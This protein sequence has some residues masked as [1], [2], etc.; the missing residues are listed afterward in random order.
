MNRWIG[1]GRLAR[2]PE[3]KYTQ[4]G[5]AVA[6]FALA[7]NER[8]SEK[9]TF[10]PVIAWEKLAEIIG[11]N[12][13]KGSQIMVEG[14]I[15][16][17]DYVDKNDGKKRYVTEIVANNI[18]FLSSKPKGELPEGAAQFGSEVPDEEIPF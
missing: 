18:E 16:I 11:N 5:K 8:G 1:I 4:T 7:T 12:L 15:Q 2:D 6:N 10:V 13:T 3:I 9:A 17:R 14:K